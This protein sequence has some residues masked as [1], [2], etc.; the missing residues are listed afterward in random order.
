MGI[1]GIKYSEITAYCSIINCRLTEWE[2]SVVMGLDKKYISV[3]NS[4]REEK[5]KAAKANKTKP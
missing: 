2:V 4:I 1:S 5:D 3:Y